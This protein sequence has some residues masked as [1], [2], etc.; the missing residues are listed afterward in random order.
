MSSRTT[1]SLPAVLLIF[2]FVCP[3]LFIQKSVAATKIC[4][5]IDRDATWTASTSPYM[6]TCAVTIAAGHTV[7]IESGVIVGMNNHYINV[8]GK[9]SGNGATFDGGSGSEAIYVFD[10]GYINL[11]NSSLLNPNSKL[12]FARGSN[13]S[14]SGSRI[15]WN[16]DLYSD[17]PTFSGNTYAND[18]FLLGSQIIGKCTSYN[19][20]SGRILA[21]KDG[22]STYVLHGSI[23]IE[24]GDV[25]AMESGVTVDMNNHYINVQGKLNGND[26]TFD[27]GSSY[28]AIYVSDGGLINLTNSSL[29]NPNS[30]LIFARGSNGS[31]SGSRIDWN[32]DLYSDKPTFS[33]NTYRLPPILLP[34]P[35]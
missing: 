10:G 5:T 25:M 19:C 11:T 4:G 27:G 31:I 16:I 24:T 30:K 26:A 20:S 8:Q 29:L 21:V 18:Y 34:Q 3:F 12:I 15:D 2:A 33:D 32:I 6:L 22:I 17:K 9:L 23:T 35:M 28:E 14:I 13:G 7:T 1:G